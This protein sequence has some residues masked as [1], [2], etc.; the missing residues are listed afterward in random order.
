MS[1][2]PK[3][4][5]PAIDNKAKATCR[6]ELFDPKQL[7]LTRRLLQYLV[8]LFASFIPNGRQT[9]VDSRKHLVLVLHVRARHAF[10]FSG[11]NGNHAK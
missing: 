1:R 11:V 7:E 2:G 4:L 6:L 3:A 10:S 8:P 9:P 5:Y